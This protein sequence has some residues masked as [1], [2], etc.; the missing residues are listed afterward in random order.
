MDEKPLF[1]EA[2]ALYSLGQFKACMERLLCLVR[3]NPKNTEAWAEIKRVKQ[4]LREEDTGSY[5]FKSMYGQAAKTPPLV[6]C[7]TYIGP[8][9][10]R[11]AGSRGK[12][13]FTTQP[14][15]AGELLF[16]EKAFAYCYAGSD[17]ATG[18]SNTTVL[19]NLDNN[20]MCVGGQARLITQIVQK[21]YHNPSAGEVFTKLHHG[22]YAP[23]RTCEV[24]GAPVVDT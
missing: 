10:V 4:R 8:V 9:A 17:S 6:D 13:L 24:D 19:M 18:R 20:T 11:D 15:K 5:D 23:V 14:V 22:D 2:K 7:A 1:R 21:I 12:G 16:C 3:C